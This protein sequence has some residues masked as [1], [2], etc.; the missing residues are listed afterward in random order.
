[1]QDLGCQPALRISLHLTRYLCDPYILE[2]LSNNS[3]TK[4]LPLTYAMSDDILVVTAGVG[5][6]TGI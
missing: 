6:A 1:M 2:S 3:G 4:C 5:V